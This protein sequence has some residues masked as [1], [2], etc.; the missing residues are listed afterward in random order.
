MQQNENDGLESKINFAI[1]P[2][3]DCVENI[4]L[5]NKIHM[6]NNESKISLVFAS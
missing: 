5:T 3:S 2:Y 1:L 6:Y 4:N